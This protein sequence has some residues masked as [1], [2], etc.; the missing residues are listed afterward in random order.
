[1][2]RLPTPG[3]DSSIWGAILNDFLKVEHNNDGTLKASGS[4][5]GKVDTTDGRLIDQR[6]PT[7]GSVT[8]AKLSTSNSAGNGNVLAYNGTGMQWQALPS[9]PVTSVNTQTGAVVLNASSVGA[10]S[11]TGGGKETSATPTASGANTSVDLSNGN[12]QML[13]LAATTTIS[14]TGATNGTACSLSLYLKQD[15]TGSRLVTW[16]AS[17]K[18]PSAAA[19]TLSTGANKIDLVVLETLDGGTI[20]YGSLAGADFR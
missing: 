15:G 7:D 10:V 16:P 12:V 17:I 13:T 18:W 2:S 4:L 14:L 19:P 1:M 5:A 20:W 8:L 6:T 3:G 11:A 9:A